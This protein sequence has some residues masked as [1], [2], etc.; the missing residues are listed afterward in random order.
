MRYM[1]NLQ[2]WE[3]LGARFASCKAS[4]SCLDNLVPRLSLSLSLLK[5]GFERTLGTRLLARIASHAWF[6]RGVVFLQPAP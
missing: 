4:C 3:L 6:F 1:F 5:D 2:P